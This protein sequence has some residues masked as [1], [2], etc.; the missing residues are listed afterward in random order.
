[1]HFIG[2]NPREKPMKRL[3]F[4]FSAV[5]ILF[6][7]VLPQLE[8]ADLYVAPLASG[9]NNSNPGTFSAPFATIQKA[10]SEAVAG[11]NVIIRGGTYR[12]TVTPANSGTANSRITYKAYESGGIFENVVISGADPVTGWTAHDTSNGRAIYKTTAMNWNLSDTRP[13]FGTIYRNQIFVNSAMMGLARWPN[14]PVERI[15]RLSYQDLALVSA[16]SEIEGSTSNSAWI[17]SNSLAG[18]FSPNYWSA[19]GRASA[20]VFLSPSTMIYG[21]SVKIASQSGN[22][23]N[24]DATGT[25]FSFTDAYYAPTKNNRF[26]I[27][28]WYD[29]LDTAGEFWKDTSNNT[30]YL[31]APAGSN[32]ATLN[33]EAKRR[34]FGLTLYGNSYLTFRGIKLF[35]CTVQCDEGSTNLEFD[36][37]EARYISHIDNYS[38]TKTTAANSREFYLRGDGHVVKNSYFNGAAVSVIGTSGTN[39]L[40][41]NNVIRDF[42]YAHAGAA[43]FGRNGGIYRTRTPATKNQFLRNTAFNGGHQLA[44]TDPALDIKHNRFY[45]SHLR[46]SDIGSVG[47]CCT[48]GLGSEIA[49]NVISDSFGPKDNGLLYGGFGIYFDY[50]CINYTVHHNLVWNTTGGS[51]QLMPTRASELPGVTDAGIK[52]YNNTG[53]KDFGI[54][55]P[56]D[57]PGVD[58]RNNLVRRYGNANGSNFTG[59]TNVAFS[60]NTAFDTDAAAPFRNASK[61]DLRYTSSSNPGINAGTVISPFTNGFVGS[62]PDAGALE[63]DVAPFLAGATILQRQLPSITVNGLQQTGSLI[64]IELGNLPEGRGPTNSFQVKIGSQAFSGSVAYNHSKSTWRIVGVNKG[65]LSGSQ[66][67]SVRLDASSPAV[68]LGTIALQAQQSET[69]YRSIPLDCG[70]WFSGFSIHPSGRLYGFGDVFGMWRS[71]DAGQSWK[72]LQGDF[73]TFDT[74]INGC[75][76]SNNADTVSFLSS[77]KL[78][79]STDGGST[80]VNLLSNLNPRRDRGAAPLIFNP[81]NNN[82][83]W[84]ASA[85]N[86]MQGT[87][88]RSADGGTTWLKAGGNTFDNVPATT[89]YIRPELPTQIWVGAAG[90]LY[91]SADSGSTWTQVWNN[92]GGIP[93]FAESGNPVPPPTVIA[94]VRRAD[95]VGYMATNTKGWQIT[96]TD[97]NN[98]SS[99]SVI[100][101][102]SWWNGWGPSGATVLADGSFLTNTNGNNFSRSYD[103]GLTWSPLDMKLLTP[104][105]PAWTVPSTL[106]SKVDGTRDM[107]VQDPNNPDRWFMT[108]GKAPVITNDSGATWNYPPILNGLAGVPTTKVRFLRGN[109]ST[110]L[111]PGADQG[112]FTVTDAGFSGNVAS[113]IASS[114]RELQTYH[115]ILADE[116]GRTLIAAGVKQTTSTTIIT[117]SIDGGSSW[118]ELDL[119]NA[120]LPP[121]YEG[122]TRAVAAPNNINDF[123]VLLGSS[124]NERDNNPG[125]YRT[126]DGGVTFNQV[127]GIPSGVETGSRYHHEN[128]WLEA[129]GVNFN[130]RY[131]S[132]RSSGNSSARGFWRSTDGGSNW[133]KTPGQPFNPDWILCMAVD[134]STEGRIWVAGGYRGVKRSDDAGDSWTTVSGFSDALSIDAAGGRIAVYG[135]RSGDTWNKIYYSD[136]NGQTWAEK[137]GPGQRFSNLSSIAVDPYRPGQL[138][139]SG[140]SVSVINPPTSLPFIILGGQSATSQVGLNFNYALQASGSPSA[141]TQISGSLPPGVSL[142]TATGVLSG[143]PTGAGSYTVTFTATDGILTTPPVTMTFVVQPALTSFVYEPF[144]YPLG[145]NNPDP[146]AGINSGNGLPSINVGGTPSGTSTGMRGTWGTSTDVTTGLTYSQGNKTLITTGGAARVNNATWGGNP[147]IY[148]SM[149]ADPFLAQR[150]GGSNNANFGVDGSSM[151]LSFLGMTS[152]STPAAFRYSLRFDGSSNFY[153]SNTT[154]GWSLNGTN[155][156]NAPL[157]LNTPTLFVVRFDFAAGA[158]DTIS[159]WI[160]PTLGA[161]LGSPNAS[162]SGISFPGIGNFQFNSAVANAMTLDELRLGSSFALVSPFSTPPPIAPTNLVATAGPASQINLNWTDNSNDELGFKIERSLDGITGWTQIAAPAVNAITYVN[163]GLASGTYY[164][165]VRAHNSAGDSSWSAIANATA[166]APKLNQSISFSALGAKSFGNAAFP[167]TGTASSGLTVSYASSNSAVA[168]VSGNLVT[169]VGAGSTTITASQAGNSIYNAASSVAQNLNVNAASQ[170]ITFGSLTPKS[171]GDAAFALTASASS[172]LTVNYTSS[173]SAVATISG[174]TLTVVGAGSATI[175]ASQAG[176]GNFSPA[177]AVTQTLTVSKDNQNITFGTLVGKTLGD[178]DFTLTAS[179]SS[180]LPVSYTSSN[181]AVAT[182]TGNTV[183]VVGAGSATITA[184]QAGSSNYTTAANVSQNLTVSAGALFISESFSYP[185]ATNNPDPDG[186]TNSNNGLP[187]TNTNGTPSGI[188]TGLRGGWGTTTDTVAGLNYAQGTNTLVTSGG[189]ARINNDNWGGQP[190]VYNNMASDPFLTK[191]IGASPTG[192]FGSD[193]TSLYVSLLGQTSSATAGAF[194]FSFK[195]DG[196]ANLFLANTS[197]GWTLGDNLATGPGTALALNTPTLFVLRFDFAV[198]ASDTVSLW[199]NP[200]L[201][202]ALGSPSVSL[203]GISFPG[204]SNFQTR[205]AV[206]NAMVLDELRVGTSLTAV[207]PYAVSIP[208]PAAPSG[209][210]ATANSASQITL[211]WVDNSSDET[212]FVL[213]RSPDGTSGWSQIATPAANVTSFVNTGL[214]GATG[215]FYRVRANNTGGDSAWS[216]SATT[217]TSKLDQ[218]ITFGALGAKSFG[219]AAFT[220]GGT[221]SSGLSVSYTS[222]NSAVATI[223]ANTVTIVGAGST[224]IT[225]SQA[226][227]ST[228]NAATITTQV[229]TVGKAGQTITFGG[230][231]AKSVGDA[232][233]SLAASASSGLAVSYTSSN[234]AVATVSGNTVTLVSTGTTTITASQSGNANY[235]AAANVT[236]SLTVQSS[237]QPVQLARWELAG[238]TGNETTVPPTSS[239]SQIT[240]SNLSRGSGLKLSYYEILYTSDSYAYAQFNGTESTSPATAMSLGHYTQF[241]VTPQAGVSLSA[242]SLLYAPYWQNQAPALANIPIAYSI[243][244]GAY[245]YATVTGTPGVNSG[246]PIT[247]TLSGIPALQGINQP[248]TFRLLHTSLGEWSFAGIGRYTGD[249]IVLTGSVSSS[250][251]Q[252]PSA[253]T[254]LVATANSSSQITLNWTDTSADESGFKIE[255]SLNGTSGWTQIA[256]PAA[257]SASFPNSGLTHLTAYYYSV[258]ATNTA[259]DSAWTAIANATTPKLSQTLT[260]TALATRINGD[261]PF[262]LT[263]S[264][265]SGL[266]VSYSSSNLSVA[267]VSGNTVTI[268]SSGATTITAS[269]AGNAS[270]NAASSVAQIL[271]VNVAGGLTTTDLTSVNLTGTGLGGTTGSS[272]IRTDGKWELNGAG[273]GLNGTTDGVWFESQSATG[274]FQIIA[275]LES[276]VSTGSDPLAGLLIRAGTGAN[277]PAA[278]IAISPTGVITTAYRTQGGV[279]TDLVNG[280]SPVTLPNAWLTLQ[281]RGVEVLAYLSIDGVQETLIATLPFSSDLATVQA[282]LFT[283]SGTAGVTS[284]AVVSGYAKVD[285]GAGALRQYWTGIGGGSISDLTGNSAYPNSPTGSNLQTSLESVNW[286]NPAITSDWADSYGQRIRGWIIAPSTGSYTFWTAG[287]DA[288]QLWLGTGASPSTKTLISSVTTWTSYREWNKVSTQKST[289]IALEAGKMYYVEVLHKE[290]GGG[291]SLSVGW[292]K[293]GQSGTIPSEIVPGSVLTPWEP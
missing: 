192:N 174:N 47:A 229:L 114:V 247:A 10:A 73:T 170:T 257:N 34:D 11:D 5:S 39:M 104:P 99:Y 62:A 211:N 236:Q 54:I 37:I 153:V 286:A 175:T 240:V 33:V 180:G 226:G 42:G 22:R 217:T 35:G 105:T 81:T 274:S 214:N 209:L 197:T 121:S 65:S 284:R 134:H 162:V 292:L 285:S 151:Y 202:V 23:L 69:T 48:D 1:M 111:I 154:T 70:G 263:A 290:G 183:T 244:G 173:N 227:N 92:S 131:L 88:W 163:T 215:Y 51:F 136:D 17:E 16:A 124:P 152:S 268:V 165:R 18:S 123:L 113:S 64:D 82:E 237:A 100:P 50:E 59:L 101:T 76:V 166:T 181:S 207:T 143:S 248:V 130:N 195:Y 233:F 228:Y 129:D 4:F 156:T 132:L 191:R 19:P 278:A 205:A 164:Y 128:S 242:T 68:S 66:P 279:W 89:I 30:L 193:G 27:Y 203:T 58:I 139:V 160:N 112:G 218:S 148:K 109:S 161:S 13:S 178:P 53:T 2:V 186:G 120:G 251:T 157:S 67:V 138:W 103:G 277:V 272:G 91:V 184:S 282:G 213:E 234:S 273:N 262:A 145:T 252:P 60:N 72:Y 249:D 239:Q 20:R 87:L 270:Y 212:G 110:A 172:G 45:N 258:R 83:M 167:L 206:V 260:F 269:Q 61:G 40:I 106:G 71:D 140:M 38:V 127:S 144:S 137:S 204:I 43:I 187:A 281:R 225:A 168:T 230:L 265:S 141:W 57:I 232:P 125:L 8:A 267:T 15:T 55:A 200:P 85:R 46:G 95:G 36:E 107:V 185:L 49:Y 44:V 90:G 75:A 171:F 118:T 116:N 147:F 78:F 231:A 255:R 261:A 77:N 276:L 190:Y 122:V 150:I 155:A 223:S 135:K 220:L 149:S 224:T 86:G 256:T 142:N 283:T 24:L 241:T 222:S 12:E 199:V 219:D 9:G 275:R 119:T 293:P 21:V 216:S 288:N 115:E 169:I 189:A 271:T 291:D 280:T 176:N 98:P 74:F 146:D 7:L 253:P 245:N 96:A 198:G 52:F 6:G 287:D 84:L 235:N 28:D 158:N 243:N 56:Q 266:A 3:N 126:I 264:A 80:W 31:W 32:P 117:R 133:A 246:S 201:G 97:Y 210:T 289:P 14:I 159:L 194:R 182:I 179:A 208:A 196:V 94:I 102:V 250:V 259:G 79:K 41:E 93:P 25:D 108:G 188:S 177:T 238:A 221:A 29:A 26:F 63:F 254:G